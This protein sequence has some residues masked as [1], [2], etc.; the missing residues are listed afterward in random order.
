MPK[1][2]FDVTD[3]T[4]LVEPSGLDCRDDQDAQAK[5]SIIAKLVANEAP[6][7]PVPRHVEVLDEDRARVSKVPVRPEKS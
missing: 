5:A 2:Y 3:G 6:A 7:A 1:Y 4:R